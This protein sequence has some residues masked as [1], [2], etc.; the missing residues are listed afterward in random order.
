MDVKQIVHA[1]FTSNTYVVSTENNNDVWLID[2]GN[3]NEAYE[4]IGPNKTIKGVFLT[5]YHYDHIYGIN[6]LNHKF[7]NCQIY[8]SA[9][10]IEGL[11]SDK[12][13]LSFYHENP[14]I[15]EGKNTHV[16]KEND[17]LKLFDDVFIKI[18]ETPGH[19]TGCLTFMINN[20]LFTGDS[21]IPNIKVVTKLK[22][23]D[24]EANIISLARIKSLITSETTV[25]P[26]HGP[27]INN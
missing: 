15:Y 1:T 2:V 27:I 13:N 8:G 6:E 10:T 22:G 26:G 7:P 3:F 11:Y 23:G 12:L 17:S 4:H 24:K 21:Y 19:N 20:Y 25:C 16:I 9:H 18:I 5:H 14:I